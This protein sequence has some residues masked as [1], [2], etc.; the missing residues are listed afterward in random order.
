VPADEILNEAA[1]MPLLSVDAEMSRLE[2]VRRVV[3]F[4]ALVIESTHR[5]KC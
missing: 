5:R 2:T 1:L 3:E 4:K